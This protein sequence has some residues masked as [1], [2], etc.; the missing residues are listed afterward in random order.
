MNEIHISKGWVT[1]ST[2][3]LN[4][5]GF[6]DTHN[7]NNVGFLL[8]FIVIYAPRPNKLMQ[9]LIAHLFSRL[10]YRS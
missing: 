7:H 8:Y 9:M 6:Y 1:E 5:L 10:S 3:S 2:T 4:A